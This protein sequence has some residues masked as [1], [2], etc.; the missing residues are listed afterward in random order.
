MGEGGEGLEG[1]GILFIYLHLRIA[2]III[3]KGL[4]TLWFGVGGGRGGSVYTSVFTY[5]LKAGVWIP[6][7]GGGGIEAKGGG[8]EIYLYACIYA[9]Q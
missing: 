7:A 4:N 3:G 2:Y 5:A 6:Q 9:L 1:G 8:E